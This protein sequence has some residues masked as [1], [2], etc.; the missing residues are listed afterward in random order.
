VQRD[1]RLRPGQPDERR[2]D[3]LGHRLVKLVRDDAPN[4]IG[5]EDLVKVA[6]FVPAF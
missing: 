2:A 5:L 1:D 6:H 4:V 3:L